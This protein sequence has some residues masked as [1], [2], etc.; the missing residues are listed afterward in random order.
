MP[1]PPAATATLPTREDLGIR[2]VDMAAALVDAGLTHVRYAPGEDVPWD[3]GLFLLDV[4]SGKVEGWVRSLAALSEE[5]RSTAWLS[6]DDLDVSPSNRF[7]SLPGILYD[8]RTGRAYRIDGSLAGWWGSGSDERLLL[9]DARVDAY[10]VVNG[11]LEPVAQ[12]PIPA[13][14]HSISAVGRYILVDERGSSRTFHLVNLE[15][16]ADP[17]VHTRVLPWEPFGEPGWDYRIELLD[18]LVVFVGS[19]GDSACHVT[20][21]DLEGVPFSDQTIPCQPAWLARISPDG[22]LIV[23]VTFDSLEDFAYDRLPVGAVLSILDAATGATVARILGAHPLWFQEWKIPDRETWLADSSGIIVRTRHGWR[24]AGLDGTWGSAPGWPSPDDPELFLDDAQGRAFAAVNQHGDARASLP[25]GPPSAAIP[26]PGSPAHPVLE[27]SAGWGAQSDTLRVWTLYYHPLSWDDYDGTPPL[28]PVIELPPFDDRL[29]VEVVVDTCLHVREEPG[30]YTPIVT[31]LPNGAVAETD[32]FERVHNGVWID[33]WMHIRTADGIK[34][35]VAADYLRWHSDGVRP[36]APPCRPESAATTA[37]TPSEPSESG[38]WQPATQVIRTDREDLGWVAFTRGEQMGLTLTREAGLFFLDIETGRV[39][40]WTACSR[41][42]PSPGNR[43]VLLES[44]TGTRLYDR[45]EERTSTWYSPSLS[46]VRQVVPSRWGQDY[47]PS[48]LGWGVDSG[49]HLV[50]RRGNQFAVVDASLRAVAWF[51]LDDTVEGSEAPGAWLA[52][53]DGQYL[54]RN[55]SSGRLTSI[56]LTLGKTTVIEAPTASGYGWGTGFQALSGGEGF[57]AIS[58]GGEGGACTVTRFGW[59]LTVLSEVSVLCIQAGLTGVDLSPDGTLVAT[60]TL[61][62]G[63]EITDPGIF[64]KLAVTSIFDAVTGE[65]VM[66]VHGALLSQ[67]GHGV[68]DGRS[69]WMADSSG[70]VLETRTGTDILGMDGGWI[71]RFTANPLKQGLVLPAPDEPGRLDRPLELLYGYCPADT[72]VDEYDPGCRLMSAVVVDQ[73]GHELASME[74]V[75]RKAPGVFLEMGDILALPYN[76]TSWGLTSRELRVHL[77]PGGPY[78]SAWY[79]PIGEPRVEWVPFADADDLRVVA[80][81]SCRHLREQRDEEAASLAC[82]SGGS[83]V[84]SVKPPPIV[85]TGYS[86]PDGYRSSRLTW[87]YGY[88]IHVRTSDGVEGW[89]HSD[90]LEGWQP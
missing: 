67:A 63:D 86:Y 40:G 72:E 82:L 2:E 77:S 31:C 64:P 15:D 26:D 42:V 11:S 46:L 43:F 23:T 85:G 62:L 36:G 38:R 32:D 4:E 75:L 7:L 61:L 17:R 14:D 76:R 59:D 51:E 90:D 45:H 50:F 19:G 69:R 68:H 37:D 79:L 29:L 58:Y 80:G 12:L 71:G 66:R 9:R 53:P 35:W 52:H 1:T 41:P 22:R 20:R 3:P 18:N 88:W 56:D 74:V 73:E 28:A 39:E 84:E 21:Y 30:H 27:E 57:A 8:R 47:T 81:G 34:G 44:P 83:V 65:E 25:F 16:E 87:S 13:G 24:V 6:G 33:F 54:V 89:M 5:E 49:E 70:L 60:V 48:L 55:H 78:E 10:V